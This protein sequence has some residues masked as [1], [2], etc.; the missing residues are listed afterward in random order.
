[1]RKVLEDLK[2]GKISVEDAEKLLTQKVLAIGEYVNYDLF[3]Q[4]R[5]GIPEVIL[6]DT[7][8]EETLLQ[9]V[10]KNV[11]VLGYAVVSRCSHKF[12]ERMGKD[13]GGVY[14]EK[15][16]VFYAGKFQPKTEIDGTVGIITGGTGDLRVAE[17]ARAILEILGCKTKI[18]HDAGV[19]GPH[20]IIKALEE[21]KDVDCY[22]VAA[23]REGTLPTLVASLVNKVVIGVPVSVG[24]GH[25]SDGEAALSTMLQSCTPVCVV[26]IDAGFTAAVISYLIVKQIS[27]ARKCQKSS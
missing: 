3:R 13:I 20:R 11:E 25:G 8:D 19:A 26:N 17:E 2:N 18:A 9:I 5:T 16:R 24:Y 12:A 4:E 14:Y 27:E 23:G 7:K 15:G 1:M 22:I 6:G 10:R 21:M